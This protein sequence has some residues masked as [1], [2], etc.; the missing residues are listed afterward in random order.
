[1]ATRICKS[2][3]AESKP[4]VYGVPRGGVPVAYLLAQCMPIT[5]V[6]QPS[7]AEIIVDD[8]IDSGRTRNR[9]AK[10]FPGKPFEV[11]FDKSVDRIHQPAFVQNWLVF[12]WES[13]ESDD[14]S[15]IGTIW[16][17]FRA[18][19]VP[20]HANDY[21]GEK[22]LDGELE[23]VRKEVQK[24]ADH[25]MRGLLIDIEKDHNSNETPRRLANMLVGELM[26]GRFYPAPA[27]TQFPNKKKLDEV[28]VIGPMS[29][30]S[31]CSHHWQAITGQIWVGVLPEKTLLGAS[32]FA[33]I[34]RW[35][36]ARPQIQEELTVQIANEL[37]AITQPKGLA[38]VIKAT[39]G[40]MTCRGIREADNCAMTTSVMRGVF[41]TK[42]EARAEVMK[43]MGF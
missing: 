6:G 41:R 2:G 14:D 40:C 39:H 23:L 4:F 5:I 28:Y 1:M 21:I 9:F 35:L 27:S 30:R 19:Q 10:E 25:L 17:R 29:L 34:A 43:L 8:L 22:L 33:R 7:E 38:V 16:N 15:V 32:K 12:P 37:Q 26:R 36:A 11:L 13:Q 18:E 20:F 24:R 3:S 31:M 42:P